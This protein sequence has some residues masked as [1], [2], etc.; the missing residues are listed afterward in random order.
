MAASQLTHCLPVMRRPQA[1]SASARLQLCRAQHDAPAEG[2]LWPGTATAALAAGDGLSLAQNH[3]SRVPAAGMAW[4][5]LRAAG[6]QC[7]HHACPHLHQGRLAAAAMGAR[8][9]AQA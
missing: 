6:W 8:V 3:D 9:A 4:Q 7:K 2:G 5:S 1:C